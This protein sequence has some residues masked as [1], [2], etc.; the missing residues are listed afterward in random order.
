MQSPDL[1]FEP[2]K[3][4][5]PQCREMIEIS[6][7]AM[8]YNDEISCASCGNAFT[9]NANAQRLLEMMKAME[10]HLSKKSSV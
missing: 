9:L 1:I 10:A 2:I 5:C 4:Y 7:E 6:L 8:Q 3:V